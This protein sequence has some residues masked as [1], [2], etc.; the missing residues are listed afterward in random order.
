MVI[1][2]GKSWPS[3]QALQTGSVVMAWAIE[4]RG[5][6]L[7]LST[8]IAQHCAWNRVSQR[9]HLYAVGFGDALH[10]A[11]MARPMT[12]LTE[13]DALAVDDA[14]I[15]H[16]GGGVHDSDLEFGDGIWR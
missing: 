9:P 2:V 12:A 14:R 6:S 11:C 1:A 13:R 4:R 8:E 5:S 7:D 3:R 10:I 15:A 16:V